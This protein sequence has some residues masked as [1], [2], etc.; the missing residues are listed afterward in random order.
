MSDT[1]IAADRVIRLFEVLHRKG[2][3]SG[4]VL[5]GYNGQAI[6]TGVYGMADYRSDAHL[7]ADSLY[8]L[9]SVT[10]PLTATA[11]QLLEQRKRL[12][13]DDPLVRWLPALPYRDVT[14][15]QAL[16]HVSGLPDYMELL[17]QHGEP[18]SIATNED[19]IRLLAERCPPPLF[20]AGE[21]YEY[22]N[23]GYVCLASVIEAA[24]GM[25]YAEF[26]RAHLFVPA[27][28][29]RSRI[30]NRRLKP[31]VIDDLAHG[32]IKEG[33]EWDRYRLPDELD[34]LNFVVRLDGIQG[35]GTAHSTLHDLL[36]YDTA[37]RDGKLLS[38]D[39]LLQATASFR[40]PDGSRTPCGFGWFLSTTPWG[41]LL[42]SHSGGWPGYW[43]RF[44]RTVADARVLI[45]L[46]N[47]EEAETESV[48]AVLDE[49]ERIWFG[50]Y[51]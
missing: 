48:R 22:S 13:Y 31:E 3:F 20:P 33:A 42:L 41:D 18:S 51:R 35:D 29:K 27:G 1:K 37:L 9:A 44:V 39:S 46:A 5:A 7:T 6:R 23:T 38:S 16:M 12:R 30:Y 15:R 8:E 34:A 10:K 11:V 21:R 40:L 4:G 24:S 47:V 49:A 14:V 28:M 32:W 2:L 17:E 50:V 45:V 19:V 36:A 26:M 43:T 25:A